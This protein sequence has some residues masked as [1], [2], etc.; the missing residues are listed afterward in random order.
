MATQILDLQFACFVVGERPL[1]LWDTDIIGRNLTY[2]NSIDPGYFEYLGQ[3]YARTLN[4]QEEQGQP[5]SREAQHAAI[6]L[7][8]AYSQAIENF[9]ALIF[10]AIQAPYCVPAWINAYKNNELRVLVEKVQEQKQIA[11]RLETEIPSFPIIYDYLFPKLNIGDEN[12]EASLKDGFIHIWQHFA[13][14]FLDEST[15]REYN[16]IKHGL[17][18]R[19]GGYQFRIGV[20]EKPGIQPTEENM[21]EIANSN[22][23]AT[24]FYS[25]KI[26]DLMPHQCLKKES[27][28]WDVESLFLAI[29][30]ISMSIFNVITA[31]KVKNGDKS[32]AVF[33]SPNDLTDFYKWKGFTNLKGGD[34]IILPEYIAPLTKNDIISIYK[35]EHPIKTKRINFID[36]E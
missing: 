19:P 18:I 21:L 10:S 1:C 36:E 13:D 30:I 2:L 31:L 5:A 32:P 11:S 15:S 17:R 16:S 22:F 26:G 29:H 7:R 12:Y 24:Y 28:T 25:Q 23:G 9:F 6:A 34:L 20:V 27:R 4:E 14:D 33:R 8:T 3:L 35:T